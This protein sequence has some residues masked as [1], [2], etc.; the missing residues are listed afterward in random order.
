MAHPP[1]IHRSPAS[2]VSCLGVSRV[3]QARGYAVW[4]SHRH[5]WIIRLRISA[6][7][8]HHK[9][10]GCIL[11]AHNLP[12][13]PNQ[14]EQVSGSYPGPYPIPFSLWPPWYPWY[15]PRPS[16]QS[17]GMRRST[18]PERLAGEETKKFVFDGRTSDVGW[19]VA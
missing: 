19:L 9:N 16:A 14:S 11:V 7:G 10:G 17:P 1:S 13:N 12:H 6:S 5:A 18:P 4:P 3:S 15:P 8:R 2:I